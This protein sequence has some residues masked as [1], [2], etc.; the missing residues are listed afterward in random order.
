MVENQYYESDDDY[1]DEYNDNDDDDDDDDNDDDD[2]D[3]YNDD[4]GYS[5]NIE[6]NDS[7]AISD[8]T[9]RN[10]PNDMEVEKLFEV[11][12]H[13]YKW[14]SHKVPGVRYQH[15]GI[16]LE[17][18]TRGEDEKEIGRT[19]EIVDFHLGLPD[20]HAGGSFPTT[21]SC[22]GSISGSCLEGMIAG[23]GRLRHL[24]LTEQEEI[25]EWHR[26][27]Y[28]NERTSDPKEIVISRANFLLS[29]PSIL[30]PYHAFT[31][32]CEC[33]AVWCKTGKWSTLQGLTILSV[34]APTPVTGSAGAAVATALRAP[35]K[36]RAAGLWGFF[37]FSTE[38]SAATAYPALLPAIG[39]VGL[40]ASAAAVWHKKRQCENN[41]DEMSDMLNK[42]Y[43]IFL[44]KR[45][46]R[47]QNNDIIP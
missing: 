36:V 8:Y 4:D 21:Q 11:G 9:D 37:G 3:D 17:I 33:V 25:N 40:G 6:E 1:D 26:V 44:V 41:W 7:D 20:E 15:H 12:D 32:N 29:N 23:P 45:S 16:V 34:L 46:M 35:V 24:C 19:I 13:V 10:Q 14:C 28:G 30:P 39:L 22:I 2:D 31:S 42:E 43:C 38:V 18:Q 47:A 27:P 5:S